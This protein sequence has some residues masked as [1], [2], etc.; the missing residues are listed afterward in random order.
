MSYGLLLCYLCLMVRLASPHLV[1]IQGCPELRLLVSVA[2]A[3]QA[4][5]LQG[6]PNHR[7][8]YIVT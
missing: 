2:G 3:K 4:S 7:Y 1:N 5:F 6:M 8:Y